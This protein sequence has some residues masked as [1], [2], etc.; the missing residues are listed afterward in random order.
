MPVQAQ[1]YQTD[2]APVSPQLVA[3]REE[4]MGPVAQFLTGLFPALFGG[5]AIGNDTAAGYAMQRDQAMG[6]I[7]LLWR[8]MKFFHAGIMELA[9]KCF[10]ESRTGDVEMASLKQLGDVDWKVIHL[11]EL[12]GHFF[13]Y[14]ETNEDFPMS[15]TQ[16]RNTVESMLQ[17]P[18]ANLFNTPANQEA[19][20]HVMG[21]LGLQFPGADAR[22]HQFREISDLMQSAP[23]TVPGPD[24]VTPANTVPTIQVDELLDDHAT[25]MQAVQEWS[26][27]AA[28]RAARV[29]N[30]QGYLNV[31]LHFQQHQQ[32]VMNQ[33]MQAAQAQAAAAPAQPAPAAPAAAP[34]GG[35]Q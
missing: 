22:T 12:Q 33:Q 32:A 3:H 14:P 30:P 1:M 26:E 13:A 25:H 2:P 23:V 20:S 10:V 34:S 31:R 21:P 28:G 5:G 16:K 7:G 8:N 19:L 24:G 9:V 6:R 17:S 4:L 15:W 35:Q 18:L 29:E 11:D 27:S